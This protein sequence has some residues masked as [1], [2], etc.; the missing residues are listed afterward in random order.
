MMLDE[1]NAIAVKMVT[2]GQGILA[3]DES[4][5]TMALSSLMKPSA[6]R[7]KMVRNLL[8][9]SALMTLFRESKLIWAPPRSRAAPARP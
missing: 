6:K 5:G 2:P 7:Q 3:A 9:Y 4:T 1:L 8:I